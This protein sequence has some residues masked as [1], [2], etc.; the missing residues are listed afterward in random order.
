MA[1]N[2]LHGRQVIMAGCPGGTEFRGTIESG[3]VG[4]HPFRVVD[5]GGN[6]LRTFDAVTAKALREGPLSDIALIN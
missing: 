1:D 2:S 3:C 4:P 6:V 5:D